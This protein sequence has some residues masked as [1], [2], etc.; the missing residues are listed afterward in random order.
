MDRRNFLKISGALCLTMVPKVLHGGLQK[1]PPNIIIIF[2]DDQGYGDTSANPH[3][4]AI[5]TPNLERLAKK[6]IT[7]TDG[8]ASACMC[9][10]SRA[11]LLTGRFH[12]RMG[13]YDVTGDAGVGFPKGEKIMPQYFKE[14]GYTTACIGKWHVG[15][16][17]PEFSYNHPLNKGFDRFWGFYG[18]THDYWKSEPGSGFNTTGYQSCGHQPIHD[19]DEIVKKIKYLTY[20]ITEKS[21]DF[22]DENKDKPFLLYIPHHAS[23][24]PLQ[25]PKDIHKKYEDLGYGPNATLIRAMMETLD[26]GVGEILDRLEKYDIAD[27]TLIF[28]TSDNGGGDVCAQLGWIYRGGK[29]N[30]LEAGIRVPTI[31]SW[32]KEL[33]RNKI[34]REPI[35]NMDFLPTIVAAAGG[36]QDAK[37]EGVNLLPYLQGKK[38]MPQRPL[39]WAMPPNQGD[40]AVRLGKWKLVYTSVGRGLFNL[41][42]DPQE[43]IDLGSKYPKKV[44]ELEKLYEKWNKKNKPSVFTKELQGKYLKMESDDELDNQ[45][46]NY[47]PTFGENTQ[48][49]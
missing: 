37:F 11:T 40:Y 39:F 7:F 27:N 4:V 41:S 8:Y 31:I 32:P 34:F 17:I 38:Q 18:S 26:K 12:G 43:L 5:Y 49:N 24:V 25:V 29:F 2:T 13:I 1:S 21:L 44:K 30:L 36:E 22:I 48:S 19:Q 23:H 45:K 33:P 15:G 46:W 14:M 6:G 28:Y 20:E 16:E 47:S 10:P 9:T 42:E 3:D 35:T